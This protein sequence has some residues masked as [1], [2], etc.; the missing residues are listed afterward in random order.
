MIFKP[1]H[2]KNMTKWLNYNLTS[3]LKI[4]ANEFEIFWILMDKLI[5]TYNIMTDRQI[6]RLN[7]N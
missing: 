2:S 1:V 7:G 6:E 4:L 3:C 5:K